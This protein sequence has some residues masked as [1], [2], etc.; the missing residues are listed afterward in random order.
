MFVA[1]LLAFWLN[2]VEDQPFAQPRVSPHAYRISNC[3]P[4]VFYATSAYASKADWN[5]K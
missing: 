4:H 5:K 1:F 3:E 2:L